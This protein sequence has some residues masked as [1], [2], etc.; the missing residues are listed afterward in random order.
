M[1]ERVILARHGE[2]E[3]SAASVINGDPSRAV[4]LTERGRLQAQR[5]G[6]HLRHEVIDLCLVTEFPRTHQT[7]DIALFGRAVPRSILA[8]FNDPL[9]GLLEGRPLPEFR[10]WFHRHGPSVPVPG[11]GESRVQTVLRYCRG[12]RKILVRREAAVL[13]VAHGLPVTYTVR[14]ARGLDLP[15]SLEGVQVDHAVPHRLTDADLHEALGAMER[16][17]DEQGTA[18]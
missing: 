2:S 18:A 17:A 14:A 6:E 1:T 5:L 13:V 10:E 12:L 4:G 9:P 11:G 15:L 8:E 16:W 7:A 3:A